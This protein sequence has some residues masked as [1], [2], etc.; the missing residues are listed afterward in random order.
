MFRYRDV[1]NQFT[2][3]YDFK[4]HYFSVQ[5][6]VNSHVQL[7]LKYEQLK[8]PEIHS[9]LMK[10]MTEEIIRI[11]ELKEEG[12]QKGPNNV[13]FILLLLRYEFLIQSENNLI[14]YDLLI[15][16]ANVCELL[17]IRMLREYKSIQRINVL[18]IKPLS[19][20]NP[21]YN[22]NTLELCVLSDSKK[23]LSQPAIVRI[24]DRFHN[25]E[26]TNTEGIFIDAEKGLLD[27]DGIASYK[28]N[29]ISFGKI[30]QRSKTVPSI[31]RRSEI[32]ENDYLALRGFLV[33]YA[34]RFM[35]LTQGEIL[36]NMVKIFFGFTPSVWNNWE[37]YKT[38]GKVIQMGYLFLI[39]FI[40]GTILA[41]C[42]SGIFA[43]VRE[44]NE[45]EFNFFKATNLVVYLK[46]AKLN[47][48]KSLVHETLTT[49]KLPI[50]C[51]IFVYELVVSKFRSQNKSSSKELKNFQFIKPEAEN[52]S[53]DRRR[54]YASTR[55]YSNKPNKYQS[56][57]SIGHNLRTASNDSLFIS[58]LLNNKYGKIRIEKPKPIDT[59][60][61]HT[62]SKASIIFGTPRQ[63]QF[64]P[65]PRTSSQMSET[66][67]NDLV[68]RL[69]ALES[70]MEEH[71][72]NKSVLAYNI[73]HNDQIPDIEV[74]M[75]EDVFEDMDTSIISH[76]DVILS[77]STI[78]QYNESD[79]TF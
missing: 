50:I 3:H 16:K 20:M 31:D 39:Q 72:S 54:S 25:G 11:S 4:T 44:N 41:I 45:D 48:S 34:N 43:K 52:R 38:S 47:K 79:D 37:H 40:I 7:S 61:S 69:V 66:T 51:I 12:H 26:L 67:T 28:F 58:E 77:D 76:K 32:H 68:N 19:E 57:S 35:L 46:M 75:D 18:F 70:L 5:K 29:H 9:T 8:A 53:D 17:A 21:T 78:E 49:F 60:T 65:P 15:A 13:I 36:F 22:F 71:F 30:I 73:H 1:S 64:F 33:D 63:R 62:P 24:L 10:P 42:L 6:S 55:R 74:S 27:S 56:L 23:F 14:C 59:T 2:R